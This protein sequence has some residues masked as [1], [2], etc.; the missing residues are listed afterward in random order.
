LKAVIE[1]I[2]KVTRRLKMKR[3]TYI[4]FVFAFLIGCA[5]TGQSP[6]PPPQVGDNAPDFSITDVLG[7]E[8][9]LSSFKDEK[10]VVLFFYAEGR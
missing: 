10:N 5:S 3:A 7:N 4:L 1:T 9:K 2:Q 6:E 8:I